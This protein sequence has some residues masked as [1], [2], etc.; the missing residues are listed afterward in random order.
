VTASSKYDWIVD[1]AFMLEIGGSFKIPA[2]PDGRYGLFPKRTNALLV[3]QR[4]RVKLHQ[5]GQ[6]NRKGLRVSVEPD[7][8]TILVYR[9]KAPK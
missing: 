6:A 2:G 1:R 8:T 3:S 5:H 9:P 7:G 4:I